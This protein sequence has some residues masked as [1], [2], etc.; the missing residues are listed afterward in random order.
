MPNSRGNGNAFHTSIEEKINDT[1]GCEAT[2][3]MH[4]VKPK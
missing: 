3:Y 4:A 2:V 1:T